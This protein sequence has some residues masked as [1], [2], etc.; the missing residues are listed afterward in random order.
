M[1][2]KEVGGQTQEPNEFKQSVGMCFCVPRLC[3][4][5]NALTMEVPKGIRAAYNQRGPNFRSMEAVVT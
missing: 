2:K 3:G 4:L 5:L 1:R